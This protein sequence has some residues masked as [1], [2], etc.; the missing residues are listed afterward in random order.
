MIGTIWLGLGRRT[1]LRTTLEGLVLLSCLGGM[2]SMLIATGHPADAYRPVDAD[3][4]LVCI[5]IMTV[6]VAV[7]LLL[8]PFRYRLGM[9]LFGELD[10]ERLRLV[11]L[12]V[13]LGAFGVS[14]GMFRFSGVFDY[15]NAEF[16]SNFPGAIDL[17]CPL[18]ATFSVA[19]AIAALFVVWT[20]QVARSTIGSG[21][22]SSTTVQA[23]LLFGGLTGMV[24]ADSTKEGWTELIGGLS[25]VIA[26]Q[27]TVFLVLLGIRQLKLAETVNPDRRRKSAECATWRHVQGTW[28]RSYDSGL[29]VAGSGTTAAN[30]ET[31]TDGK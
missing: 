17:I 8:M 7:A 11:D 13:L 15:R 4:L 3:G 1:F 26:A 12:F 21:M 19:G 22:A 25:L 5:S 20:D 10:D 9:G 23:G 29:R 24:V 16:Y 14:L 30:D 18:L 2:A 6:P 28:R 31:Q 27:A